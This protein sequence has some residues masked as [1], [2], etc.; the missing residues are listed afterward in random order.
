MVIFLG[1]TTL[2]GKKRER[3]RRRNKKIPGLGKNAFFVENGLLQKGGKEIRHI[4]LARL[5]P[6]PKMLGFC[7][8]V[9]KNCTVETTGVRFEES[10][11][12][13]RTM[14]VRRFI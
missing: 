13:S 9:F 4:I 6:L 5:I 2:W 11:P 10:M 12:R 1:R 8:A 14:T 3:Q 7:L